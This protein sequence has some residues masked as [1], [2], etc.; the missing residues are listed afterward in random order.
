[1]ILFV[2]FLGRWQYH[3]WSDRGTSVLPPDNRP[4]VALTDLVQPNA[5]LPGGSIGRQTT[6]AGRFDGA[7]QV[8]VADRQ[9]G[10]RNGFW[11][12]TPLRPDN[13]S[14]G[15][16]ALVVRG[17]VP[18]VDDAALRVPDTRVTVSGRVY[19]SEDPPPVGDEPPPPLA[20]GQYREVNSAELTGAFPY[21]ILDGYVLQARTD[22][23]LA[24]AQP[25][26]V[27]VPV[28]TE[29]NGGGIRNLIYAIQWWLFAV[30]VLY[31]WGRLVRDDLKPPE[32]RFYRRSDPET[33]EAAG[34]GAAPAPPSQPVP[35]PV[36][37]AAPLRDDDPE[38]AELAAY[39]RWL[40]ELN[41]RPDRSR[42]RTP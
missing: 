31:F 20:P 26:V 13:A 7:H 18:S 21:R 30:A 37:A 9:L 25:T 36:S 16:A 34:E 23:A 22:P 38:D 8:L 27:P 29:D 32:E 3:R 33:A 11:V 28:N 15:A 12:V 19:A 39:N 1:V 24:G 17:W 4:A 40:A 41:A 5:P 10:G 6:V 42:S 14:A 2:V 35:E